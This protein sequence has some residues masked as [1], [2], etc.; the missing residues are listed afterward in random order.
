MW[1]AWDD[2]N[3]CRPVTPHPEVGKLLVLLVVRND[4][5]HLQPTQPEFI[6]VDEH[7]HSFCCLLPAACCLL[8]L[9]LISLTRTSF[10]PSIPE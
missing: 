8:M 1:G 6:N 7:T 10:L 2:S 4:V 5:A 9:L 3:S